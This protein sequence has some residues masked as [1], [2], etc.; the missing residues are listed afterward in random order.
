MNSLQIYGGIASDW[1]LWL[2]FIA[3][4]ACA[5]IASLFLRYHWQRYE[6]N[7]ERAKSFIA[8]YYIVTIAL[9]FS[10]LISLIAYLL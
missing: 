8:G 1:V 4:V 6:V 3:M 2:L 9:V 7:S 5:G 10:A